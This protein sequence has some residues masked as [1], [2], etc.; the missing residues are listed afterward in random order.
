MIHSMYI[1]ICQKRHHS[2]SNNC[3]Y[4][5]IYF[6][7]YILFFLHCCHCAYVM[8]GKWEIRKATDDRDYTTS[9]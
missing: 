7:L 1:G 9:L 3:T 5:C 4:A 2:I 6:N 8:D